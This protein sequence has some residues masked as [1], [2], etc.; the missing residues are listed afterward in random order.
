MNHKHNNNSPQSLAGKTRN[1]SL[2]LCLGLLAGVLIW[3]KLRLVTDIPR[4]AYAD[5][6]EVMV[7]DELL[8]QQDEQVIKINKDEEEQST[9]S[10]S[11]LIIDSDHEQPSKP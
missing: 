1:L 3:A 11:D 6:R 10:S 8:D 4:S 7:P 5:P 9:E 2:V